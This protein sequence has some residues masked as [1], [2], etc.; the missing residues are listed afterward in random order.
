MAA[1]C[2]RKDTN[3]PT[4][5]SH[6]NQSGGICKPWAKVEYPLLLLLDFHFLFK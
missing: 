1:V 3:N 4:A 5:K 2:T 6:F